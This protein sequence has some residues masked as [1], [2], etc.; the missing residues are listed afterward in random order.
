MHKQS[1]SLDIHFSIFETI[2]RFN[3][4][5][6]IWHQ[7]SN[8]TDLSSAELSP[9]NLIFLLSFDIAQNKNGRKFHVPEVNVSP[10]SYPGAS[11]HKVKHLD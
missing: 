10:L 3:Y 2:G 7:S 9:R 6:T 8:K 1:F 11:T 5:L 4:H